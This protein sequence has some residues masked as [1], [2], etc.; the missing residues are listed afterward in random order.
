MRADA[1]NWRSPKHLDRCL[2]APIEQLSEFAARHP[3]LGYQASPA[4]NRIIKF[5]IRGNLIENVHALQSFY[6]EF[7]Q[8][9][10]EGKIRNC[11][12]HAAQNARF[13]S[14]DVNLIKNG[15]P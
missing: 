15:A 5:A 13:M 6:L 14:F 8:V 1:T 7:W 9:H 2:V 12:L 10:F 4:I 3:L 11:T